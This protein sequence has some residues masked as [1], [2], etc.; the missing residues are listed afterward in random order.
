[1]NE[2]G[3]NRPLLRLGVPDRFLAHETRAQWLEELRL[4]PCGVTS[5]V[6]AFMEGRH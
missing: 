4:D 5:R 3:M 2:R 1:M 6:L